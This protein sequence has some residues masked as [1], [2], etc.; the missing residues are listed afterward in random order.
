[1]ISFPHI[2]VDSTWTTCGVFASLFSCGKP[3]DI[4]PKGVWTEISVIPVLLGDFHINFPYDVCYLNKDIFCS[5]L[6]NGVSFQSER[7]ERFDMLRFS[8]EKALLQGA[9]NTASRA[10]AAK[11]SIPALEGILLE[12]GDTLTLSGYN[13]QTGIRTGVDA[14]IQ[15]PGRI[16]LSARLFGEM[17][18]KMPDDV[19]VF[20]A[21]DKLTVHL[22]CGDA[23]FEIIGLSADDYPE[24]PDVDD[25]FSVDIRQGTLKAM[26]NQTS[27]AVSTNESRPVHTGSLFEVGDKDLTVVSVDGF[28]L[29]LRRE[30]LDRSEGGAFKFVAPGS[31]LNEV[32][33]ICEDSDEK[34][35]IIQGKRHLLFEAGATQLICRRLEGDFLDYKN[36]IPRNNP[37]RLTVDTKTMLGS[38]D[39]VSVVISEKLKSPV[40]CVFENGRVM[41]SARTGAGEA[42]DICPLDGDGNGLEIGFNNRYLMDALRYAPA[43]AVT[44][45][46]NTSISP[47][48]L[49]PVDGEESFLYMVLPVRLKA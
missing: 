11:S 13:M 35:T 39:R 42:K 5:L 16:V 19:I 37:I 25:Q 21:D 46:L 49:V 44:M 38:L 40:R 12:G 17:I 30:P 29:A 24:L 8:C 15:S 32:E 18:R 26:I 34:I 27:F 6:E 28:R 33:K 31:A 41:L 7:K 14:Q 9:V 1:M 43:D 10:V 23:S 4:V 47:A 22:T 20:D 48:V 2:P 36:A 3:P 45:E